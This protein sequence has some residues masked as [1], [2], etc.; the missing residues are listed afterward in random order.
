MINVLKRSADLWCRYSSASLE[1]FIYSK[2]ENFW[3]TIISVHKVFLSHPV[4]TE[5]YT[6]NI[7]QS[8]I[9]KIKKRT[10]YFCLNIHYSK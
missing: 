4:D 1:S 3:L 8:L 7:G 10:I 9:T 6:A 2:E 5:N